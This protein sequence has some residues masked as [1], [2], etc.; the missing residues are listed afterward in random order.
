MNIPSFSSLLFLFCSVSSSQ[1]GRAL[2]WREMWLTDSGSSRFQTLLPAPSDFSVDCLSVP[3]SGM[4]KPAHKIY[5]MFFNCFAEL[6]DE[7]LGA[8]LASSWPLDTPLL[9][10]ASSCTDANTALVV[11]SVIVLY[12]M[13]M[14]LFCYLVC[15]RCCP[16]V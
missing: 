5:M 15:G 6:L 9:S 7:N 14:D 2:S 12:L 16:W 13:V 3:T 1:Q 4:C 8:D 11:L 10:S